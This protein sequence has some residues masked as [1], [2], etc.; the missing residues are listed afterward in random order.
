LSRYASA[1]LL[2]THYVVLLLAS[3]SLAVGVEDAEAGTLSTVSPMGASPSVAVSVTGTGFNTT[4]SSN[5]VTFT[6]ASGPSVTSVASAIATLSAATGL[7]R[8][9]VTVPAGLPVGAAAL[10]VRNKATGEI[11]TGKSLDIIAISLPD[12]TSAS[13]GASNVNV[14]IAGSPN[15]AFVAG[16]TRATFG[17]GVTVNATTVESPNSLVANIS[18]S[19]TAALGARAVSVITNT[20]TVLKVGAFSVIAASLN[21]P[22]VW[23]QVQNPTVKAGDS[24]DVRLVATDP[25]GDP[26]TLSVSPLPA[27]ATFADRGD[28]TGTLSLHPTQPGTYNFTATATDSKG[29]STSFVLTVT[30]AAIN[31]PPTANAQQV[32]LAEDASLPLTLSGVDPEGAPVSFSIVLP[33]AHGS[34]SGTGG[35]RLYTPAAD[36]YGPDSFQF[37]ANDGVSNSNPATVAITVTEVNDP[38]VLGPD[39]AKLKYAGTLPGVPPLPNCGK[40]CGIIYGDP[41]LLTYDIG[42]YDAQ[43]VG[44][45]IA[46]KS[47]TDDFEVQARFAPPPRQRYV[48][49]AVAVAMRVA[50]HRVA[51]YRTSAVTGF[52]TRIDGAFVTLSASPQQLPGGGTVGTYGTNDAAAVTWPDGSVVIVRAVGVFPEYY[53]FIVEVGPAPTHLGH[54]VGM[55]ADADGNRANDLVTRAGQQIPY[56]NPP[57]ATF[58]GTYINSWRVSMA[59]SLFD[60]D[61]GD[62][63]ATFT[64]LTFPDGPM[65]PSTLTAPARTRA[66]N[67]CAQFG[68]TTPEMNDAC[69]VDVGVTSDADFA[70]EGAAVQAVGLGIPSNAGS[71]SVG[72]P[73]A[74]TVGTPG[75]TAVRTLAGT[76]GQKVTLSV[77]GNS[78]NPGADLTLIDPNGNTVA[79]LPVTSADAFHDAFTLP[80]TGTYAIA[81]VPRN[82]STGS[83]TFDLADVPANSGSTTV[84]AQT[85]VSISAPGQVGVRTFAGIAGQRLTLTVISDGLANG[86]DVTVHD[87]SGGVVASLAASGTNVFLDTFTLPLTGT[88][89][90]TVDPH[91]QDTGDL[92]YILSLVPDDTSGIDLSTP[93]TVNIGTVGE[94]ALRTF[95]GIAN[96]RVTL[97]VLSNSIPDVDL[98][99]L[100]PSG[101]VVTTQR[102]QAATA[103]LDA[104][105]LPVTGTY[106]VRIDP[107]GQYVGMFQFVVLPVPD[108]NGTTAFSLPTTVTIPT[109]GEVATRTFTAAAG[110]QAQLV[111]VANTI[112]GADPTTGVDLTIRDPS[113]AVVS[114][115][116]VSGDTATGDVFTLP[117]TGTYTVTVDPRGPLTGS[118][119]F[120]L[121]PSFGGVGTVTIGVP[122]PVTITSVG[123]PALFELNATAGP[124]V[125]LSVTANTISGVNIFVVDPLSGLLATVLPPLGDSTSSAFT[126]TATGT[127][128]IEIIGPT[129]G[130]LTFTLVQN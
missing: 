4:A 98:T 38:P 117:V 27:F 3:L 123:Q 104:F 85:T 33:P 71:T 18:V 110:Q 68:L 60:Y 21:H 9:T 80:T 106:T 47:T 55:L 101:G 95:A 50:G 128:T 1:S 72:A 124:S 56:P 126:L 14:R 119:I 81:I 52:N 31:L 105:T 118:L 51:F 77:S 22:P 39:T 8:L 96:E 20:Q 109:A 116:F 40:P 36:Y 16:G 83:L 62:T 42:F 130:S 84:G 102:V 35:T 63:T 28:G 108:N 19:T 115:L 67:V 111:V 66:T 13:P 43:A 7:R 88:Y 107:R 120:A 91:G 2:K 70:T 48:S 6:P 25:D 125:S 30:V 10:S 93:T 122:T 29:A 54:V 49:V 23:A 103:F 24:L 129:A 100:D 11:S 45:L 92:T 112:V 73:T 15:A 75:T 114:T 32:T 53:R 61:N 87:P 37:V 12:I 76:A 89:D 59:E 69:L 44:E 34:L 41:H 79:T 74:V 99:V 121:I 86:A 82:Q 5:E 127:Y 113:N 17:A 65:T 46:T 64:D 97:L 90:V 26:I 57:F 78:I 58:Y 94:V